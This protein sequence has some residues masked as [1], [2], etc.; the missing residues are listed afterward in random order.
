MLLTAGRTGARRAREPAAPTARAAGKPGVPV[1][2][3]SVH[4]QRIARRHIAARAMTDEGGPAV[5]HRIAVVIPP[6][7]HE[8]ILVSSTVRCR[9]RGRTGRP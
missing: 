5:R 3:A 1:A 7:R 6:S 9:L 2:P 8:V 4:S